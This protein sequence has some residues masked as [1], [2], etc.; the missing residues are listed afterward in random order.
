MSLLNVYIAPP[1]P[2]SY[3]LV[4]VDTESL[5]VDSGK[6]F[7]TSKLMPIVHM[8]AVLAFRGAAAVQGPIASLAATMCGSFDECLEHAG[9]F[10]P[11]A[12]EGVN[13]ATDLQ[14]IPRMTV[15]RQ[16][17]ALVGW[18]PQR[19]RFVGRMWRRETLAEGFVPIDIEGA[20]ILGGDD[21]AI[22]RLRTPTTPVAMGEL[23]KVQCRRLR[24]LE[25]GITVGGRFIVAWLRDD[26]MRIEI[27]CDLP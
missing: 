22:A 24:E 1:G 5:A 18:S 3:A 16:E 11:L 8:N 6:R 17:I 15:E 27:V 2:G 25:P 20:F 10:I 9:S 23:A 19:G 21:E 13:R 4:G 14:R 26:G 12:I 7:E